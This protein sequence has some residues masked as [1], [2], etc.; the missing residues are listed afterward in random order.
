M[1]YPQYSKAER[2]ADGVVHVFGIGAALT[3]VW[4][5][6]AILDQKLAGGTYTAVAVYAGALVLMLS[7]SGAYHILAHTSARP[8]LRRIDHAAIYVKIAGTFTPLTV[9]LGSGFA[10]VLLALV[11]LLALI[12]A[13]A[14]LMARRGEMGTAWLPYFLLGAAGVLLFVPLAGVVSLLSLVLMGLGGLLYTVGILFYCW[15]KLPYANA[16]W[17]VFVLAA[18]ASFFLGITTALAQAR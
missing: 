1:S 9:M 10:Y 7:A 17:H 14:K 15:E 2:I 11:W 3:G 16:I 13:S 18:S 8:I 12:G 6:F 4:V 5:L